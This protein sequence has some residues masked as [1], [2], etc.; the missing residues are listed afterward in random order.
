MKISIVSSLYY[1]QKYIEDF[2]KRMIQE[3]SKLTDDFE[4][5]LVDDGS[6]DNSLSIVKG[7]SMKDNRIKII[8]LSRNYGAA[9]A[10]WEGMKLSKGELVFTLDADLEE[11]P[12]LL[13]T[14][15]DKIKSNEETDV[16]FGYLENR[17]GGIV[18]KMSGWFF[19]NLFK[20]LSGI[21]IIGSPVWAR[22]MRRSYV[23]ALLQ[24]TEQH[25]FA[26]GIMKIVGFKQLGLP[27][28]K[29]SKGYT[30]YSLRKKVSQMLE[31]F[32]SFSDKP[33]KIISS[34]GLFISFLSLLF[35]FYILTS[36][37]FFEEYQSGW[38][39]L[40]ASVFFVGGLNL[41]AIGIIG[42]YVGKNFQQSKN[43]PRAI[44]KNTFNF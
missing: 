1:S 29:K 3:A 16:V 31:S 27:I 32:I 2:C 6:P 25:L 18:E 20:I 38:S 11:D 30:S 8:E 43:R 35:I 26:I 28:T 19:Y 42:L 15:Y 21:E 17:K 12:S 10:R 44:V 33:L 24:H 40:I 5:I 7:L 23:E 22:L 41:S 37:L 34:I 9:A 14:F 36:K 13:L 4:L 39:S